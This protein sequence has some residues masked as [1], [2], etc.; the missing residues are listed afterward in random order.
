MKD[1]IEIRWYIGDIQ[2]RAKDLGIKQEIDNSACLSILEKIKSNH[3]A[4]VGVN[5][6]VIDFYLEEL[7]FK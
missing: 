5:W 3:D 4:G 6:E 7:N 2:N 1:Y